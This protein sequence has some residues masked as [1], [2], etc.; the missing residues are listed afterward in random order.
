MALAAGRSG[1]TNYVGSHLTKMLQ[2]IHIFTS[3]PAMK[4]GDLT[5]TRDTMYAQINHRDRV[6]KDVGHTYLVP[7]VEEALEEFVAAYHL[8]GIRRWGHLKRNFE[9][10]IAI[11]TLPATRVHNITMV[12]EILGYVFTNKGLLFEALTKTTN[13]QEPCPTFDRSLRI[14]R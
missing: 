11:A 14:S 5:T 6:Y 9:N 12:E 1:T 10:K 3:R 4:S 13:P 2:A 8:A 7:G